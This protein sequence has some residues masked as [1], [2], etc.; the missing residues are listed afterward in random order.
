VCLRLSHALVVAQRS[1]EEKIKQRRHTPSPQNPLFL[2]FFF[3][4]FSKKNES[5]FPFSTGVISLRFSFCFSLYTS[6]S[7]LNAVIKG[8]KNEKVAAR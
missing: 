2:I 8:E 1:Y 3:E 6:S 7:V 4:N 5:S